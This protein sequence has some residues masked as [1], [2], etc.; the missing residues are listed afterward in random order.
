MNLD[1]IL[2]LFIVIINLILI[3]FIFIQIRDTRKPLILTGIISKNKEPIDTPSVLESGTLYV[4]VTNNS[5]NVAK[6]ININ[7]IFK[8]DNKV[9]DANKDQNKL[10][11]LNPGEAVKILLKTKPIRERYPDLFESVTVGNTTIEIPKKTLNMNLS[12]NVKYNP[13]IANIGKYK[14]EDTYSIKWFSQENVPNFEDHPRFDSHNKRDTIYV[15]K[16]KQ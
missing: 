4:V 9:I 15:Y 14:I 8:F 2:N 7:Y 16:T 13:I 3:Y 1:Q 6:S 12:L 11:Y 10:K 5:K